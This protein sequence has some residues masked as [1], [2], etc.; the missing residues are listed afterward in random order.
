[1]RHPGILEP[2]MNQHRMRFLLLA[3]AL[4]CAGTVWAQ[5]PPSLVVFAASSLSNVLQDASNLYAMKNGQTVAITFASS[6]SLAHQIEGGAAVDLFV[7]ADAEWMDYVE[8]RHL[9]NPASRRNLLRTR[10]ALI[11]PADSTVKL[12]I[13]PG[14]LLAAALGKGRLAVGN[15]ESVPEGRYA[16]YALISLGV[17]NTVTD[18][19]APADSGRAVLTQVAHGEAPL[20]IVYETDALKQKEVRIVG[21]FPLDSHPQIA[22]PIA[23]TPA[24]KAGAGRYADFLRGPE[25]REIFA[26]YGFKPGM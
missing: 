12:P 17:W 25:A 11:A 8:K 3:I 7:S 26:K 23:L 21:V 18:H 9:I 4:V 16:R 2:D 15:P 14:F 19:L 20:G 5:P 6:A 13:A 24:A 1:M 10:L 22:Y